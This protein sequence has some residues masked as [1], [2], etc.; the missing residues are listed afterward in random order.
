MDIPDIEDEAFDKKSR[1]VAGNIAQAITKVQ[2]LNELYKDV[3][4]VSLPPPVTL[5][6]T[7]SEKKSSRMMK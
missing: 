6:N 4:Q 2:D 1:N 3:K 5:C 7:F